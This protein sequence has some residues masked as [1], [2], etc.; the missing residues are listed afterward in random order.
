MRLGLTLSAIV[1]WSCVAGAF[2]AQAQQTPTPSEPESAAPSEADPGDTPAAGPG[3]GQEQQRRRR[4]VTTTSA[5][6]KIGDKTI[7][8]NMGILKTDSPD[9]AA[10]ANLKDGD[11]LLLTRSQTLK[12]KSDLPLTFGDVTLKTENVAE[13]YAGVYGI[14]IRKTAEG[15]DFV[16]NE[17]PDVWGT[18]Y[19][20]AA[21]VAEVPVSY[22]KLSEPTD[23]LKL[24]LP[25]DGRGG[26]LKITWGEH[27][28]TAPF[29]L[30]D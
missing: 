14:W 13:G 6:L 16:F 28:W 5:Q 15:W 10:I 20:P 22:A 26:A 7:S 29:T 25:Q 30:A 23:A 9:Y 3:A 21:D 2:N 8:L 18:M 1:L 24:S 19:D 17:R 4:L 12:L 11:V 27:E